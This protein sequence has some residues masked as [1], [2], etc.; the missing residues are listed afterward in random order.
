MIENMLD[1]SFSQKTNTVEVI[2]L[3]T[4]IH[5]YEV[6]GSVKPTLDGNWVTGSSHLCVA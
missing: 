2:Y 5:K 6:S 4:K 3:N 1:M